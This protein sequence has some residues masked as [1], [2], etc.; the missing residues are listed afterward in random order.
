MTQRPRTRRK[1]QGAGREKKEREE[2]C[3]RE[4][5]E[6]ERDERE[7]VRQFVLS[8]LQL[9]KRMEE[10]TQRVKTPVFEGLNSSPTDRRKKEELHI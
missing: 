6:R 10:K 1:E 7:K 5:R 9:T 2:K 8:K 3:E 4:E